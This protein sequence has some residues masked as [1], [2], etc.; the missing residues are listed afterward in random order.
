MARSETSGMKI[1]VTSVGNTE[2]GGWMIEFTRL[3]VLMYGRPL[4]TV[5][6]IAR[7]EGKDPPTIEAA[8]NAAAGIA[9]SYFGAIEEFNKR[10]E[11]HELA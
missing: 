4:T 6:S 9:R 7:E 11:I 8:I 5:V 2:D 10:A 3:N 1:R